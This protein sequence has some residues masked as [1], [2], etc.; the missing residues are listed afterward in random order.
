MLLVQCI[1]TKSA[2]YWAFNDSIRKI[3]NSLWAKIEPLCPQPKPVKGKSRGRPAADQRSIIEFIIQKLR[4]G[5]SWNNVQG[6]TVN[7]STGHLRYH[8][9]V[10]EGRWDA[11]W[12]VIIANADETKLTK[13]E[14]TAATKW[15]IGLKTI[16]GPVSRWVKKPV[17]YRDEKPPKKPKK[18]PPRERAV[19]GQVERCH[20]WLQNYRGI[21]TRWGY[22]RNTYEAVLKIAAMLIWWKRI[23]EHR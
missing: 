22:R 10:K 18:K 1:P 7:G 13:A 23:A 11:I 2:G 21:H 5:D 3:P 9:L 16:K 4:S 15:Q 20:A 6:K 12:R 14:L 19:R 17:K 8:A